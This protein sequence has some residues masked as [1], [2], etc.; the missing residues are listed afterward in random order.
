MSIPYLKKQGNK[1]LL[2]VGGKPFVLLAG[3]A[4]NSAASSLEHMLGVWDKAEKIGMNALLLPVY[5]E[6]T[7][8]EE[9]KFDFSLVDGLLGQARERDKKLVLLWFGSWKNAECMYAPAWVKKDLCRFER[10]QIVKGKNKAPRENFY[11]LPYTSLSYLCEET[12]RADA[13]AFAALMR[14]L[15]ETDGKEN[16]VVSVQ[17]ENETGLLGAARE[18]SDKA[19]ALFYGGVPQEFADALRARTQTMTK[20][21]REAV[22]S[23]A[24]S[25]SWKEVFGAA[26]EEIFS[27]YHIARYV[28]FV[29]AAGKAEYPL[30]M[31]VNCWLDKGEPAGRYPSG[32]PVSRMHEVWDVCAPH[33]DL[34]G[35]DIYVPYFCDV[36]DE[37]VRRGKPLFIPECA[38]HSYAAPRL[39]YAVGHYHAVCYAPFGFEE[40]GEPFSGAQGYLFGV[41]VT[42]P[43]LKTPQNVEEYAAFSRYLRGMLPLIAERYGTDDLQAVCFERKEE[44]VLDFGLFGVQAAFEHPMLQRR[45][46]VCLGIKAAPDECFLLACRCGL[47]FFSEDGARP[48]LDILELEEGRFENGKWRAFRRLNG[49]EAAFMKYDEPVLLRARVFLYD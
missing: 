49:D 48:N 15:R 13:R 1:T 7:E 28:D 12:R 39:V 6:L 30:P 35:P 47:A 20:D 17:V 21:V 14:H 2:I 43:A 5:W 9:G 11:N 24:R 29:A 36:C 37:Y 32:G 38:T 23:G 16:T 3:E 40:M 31:S 22:E 44:N 26:A 34:Y 27:A 8:P 18:H 42:D 4:H 46:G 33:I 45:D 25:G 10:A 19:D 41:D